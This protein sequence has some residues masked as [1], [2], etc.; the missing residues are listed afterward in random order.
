MPAKGFIVASREEEP[1]M[2]RLG[3]LASLVCACLLFSCKPTV[4]HLFIAA[5]QGDVQL[6]QSLLARG[7]LATLSD[8]DG[9][10]ALHVAT[11]WGREEVALVLIEHRAQVNAQDREGMTPLHVAAKENQEALA[12]ILL[13]RG[14]TIEATNNDG[15]PPSMSRSSGRLKR[16]PG[17]SSIMVRRS[18]PPIR[19]E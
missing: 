4:E 16:W 15:A 11:R 7:A 13:D 5:K 18:T 1:M 8:R 14:A 2:T 19:M 9:T 3:R 12:R 17:C 6:M 10:T